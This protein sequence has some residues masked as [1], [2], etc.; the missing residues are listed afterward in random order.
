VFIAW[1]LGVVHYPI[2]YPVQRILFYIGLTGITLFILWLVYEYMDH[3]FIAGLGIV[4]LFMLIIWRLEI[5][6]LKVLLR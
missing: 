3:T 4:C 5:N 2:N 6:R 1:R